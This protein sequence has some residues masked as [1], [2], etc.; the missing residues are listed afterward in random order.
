MR[1]GVSYVSYI[2]QRFSK[3]YNKYMKSYN[4]DK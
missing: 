1:G 3:P 4:K 2:A